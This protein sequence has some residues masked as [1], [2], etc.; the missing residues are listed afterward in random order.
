MRST[1][2]CA[3]A[4]FAAICGMAQTTD[5]AYPKGTPCLPG[6]YQTQSIPLTAHQKFCYFVQKRAITPSAVFGAAFSAGYAQMTNN[7]TEWGGG[8]DAYW[9][10]FGTRFA[11]G[12]SKSTAE[13]LVG[14]LDHEDPRLHASSEAGTMLQ[15]PSRIMPRLGR[16]VL[17]SVWTTR[18][19]YADGSP[20]R[21]GLAYS[22]MA[23]AFTSGFIGMSWTPER[24]NT[25][26]QAFGRAGTGYAGYVGTS[27]WTEF[28]PD[29]LDLAARMIGRRHKPNF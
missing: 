1:Q 16:A 28:Q 7:P 9:K 13:S 21:A 26:G 17:G 8:A 6:N 5:A 22:R 19:A 24:N 11:Q 12:L 10:R 20:R 29:I 4:V 27:V 15:N 23:G 25:V 18:D 3:L 14:M 2:L